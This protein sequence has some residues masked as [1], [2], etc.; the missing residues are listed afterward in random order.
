MVGAGRLAT[1]L[2]RALAEAGHDILAVYSR[3]MA[4]ARQLAAVVGCYATDS[5][6]RLPI[7][8]DAFII[9]VKDDALAPLLSQLAE[10][11]RQQCF[12]HTAG[13]IPMSVFDG[14]VDHYGVIYPAQTFSK[15]R[16]IS[17]ARVPFFIEGS[18]DDSLRLARQIASSVSENVRELSSEQRRYLHLA[19]VFACNFT[20]HCYALAA[21][22]LEQHGIPFDAMLPLIDETAAKVHEL[23]PR[24][25][26]TGP[27]IRYD[28]RIINAQQQLLADS[29]NLQALYT[30]LSQSIH[31][32][33]KG[34]TNRKSKTKNRK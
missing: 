8:A 3:T 30:A 5:I 28:E 22:I 2:G 33:V 9:A 16:K 31:E 14:Q 15:E 23:H 10:G 26:Q 24:D 7:E 6:E 18:D 34:V 21:E 25:A 19:A 32:K 17:L 4:S 27:A 11:R 20:N 1:Q 29:P 13:S 12:F